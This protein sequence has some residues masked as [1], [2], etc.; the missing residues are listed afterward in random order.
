MCG[1]SRARGGHQSTGPKPDEIVRGRQSADATERRNAVASMSFAARCRSTSRCDSDWL[2]RPWRLPAES[3]A[4]NL[5]K[6]SHDDVKGSHDEDE[7]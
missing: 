4:S 5:V 2:Q 3:T 7:F 6:G 1:A